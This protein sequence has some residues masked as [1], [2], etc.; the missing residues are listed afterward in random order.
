MRLLVRLAVLAAVLSSPLAALAQDLRT[1]PVRFAPGA[2]GATLRGSI[3][4]DQSVAY[5]FGAEAGQT[6]RL[7]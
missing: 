4:G 5:T 3:V 2:I 1:V 7:T 6:L